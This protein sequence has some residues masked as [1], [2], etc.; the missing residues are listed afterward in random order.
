M[1]IYGSKI[2]VN[3]VLYHV[4][5]HEADT[6]EH[7]ACHSGGLANQSALRIPHL[8]LL[9]AEITGGHCTRIASMYVLKICT[10]VLE[11]AEKALSALQHLP[12]PR[13]HTFKP[14]FCM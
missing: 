4:P 11:H 3:A 5:P 2:D 8:H 1:H 7:R 13:K 9:L 10:A 12:R 14:L 6:S